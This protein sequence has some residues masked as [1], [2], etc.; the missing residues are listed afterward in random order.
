MTPTALCRQRGNLLLPLLATGVFAATGLALM[1]GRTAQAEAEQMATLKRARDVLIGRAV[2]DENRPGS[3]PCPDLLTD[4][5]SLANVPGDGKADL[6]TRDRCPTYL[7]RLPWVTLDMPRMDDAAGEPLWYLPAPGLRDDDSAQPINSDSAGG[8]DFAGSDRIAALLIAPGPPLA[9][10][11]RPSHAIEDY[12]EGSFAD[13]PTRYQPAGNDRILPV[14]LRELMAATE[15]RVAAGIRRCLDG[16]ARTLGRFPWPSPLT[17]AS[18][19]GRAGTLFGRLPTSQPSPGIGSELADQQHTLVD[20]LDQLAGSHDP[21]TQAS[22]LSSL[23][24]RSAYGAQLLGSVKTVADSLVERAM[25][26]GQALTD[27]QAAIADATA[28]GRIARSEGTTISS[29][30][31]QALATVDALDDA[32]FRFGL[33]AQAWQDGEPSLPGSNRTRS[34]LQSARTSLHQALQDFELLDTAEPRPLQASLVGPAE[35]LSS[36]VDRPLMV[37]TQISGQALA[38]RNQV[39]E[40]SLRAA[41]ARDSL[42]KSGGAIAA[43]ATWQTKPTT[44]NRTKLDNALAAAQTA[45]TALSDAS[46]ALAASATGGEASAWPMAWASTWCDFLALSGSNWWQANDWQPLVFYQIASP[47]PINTLHIPGAPPQARVVLIAGRRLAGQN[48]PS[49]D[50][51]DYLEGANA[52][53]SRNGEAQAPDPHFFRAPADETFNDQLA[54]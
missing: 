3:L 20:S 1:F 35:T 44:A 5:S 47:T 16:H 38:L 22:L 43:L 12:L 53:P 23:A 30:G 52:S 6:L 29:R 34:T 31:A 32:L 8:L 51:A 48:R 24:E 9:G 14:T 21:A 37:S 11:H 26:S 54:Y 19:E 41:E 39:A 46:G 10:Q 4:S 27:L 28:N 13:S 17:E 7:G 40:A 33:D 42:E 15:Q 18:G 50:I 45:L 25:E 36:A 2:T 49:A